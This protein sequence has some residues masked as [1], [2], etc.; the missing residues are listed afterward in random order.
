M[1]K[2]SALFSPRRKATSGLVGV[3]MMSQVE[4]TSSKSP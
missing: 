4:K 1:L 2:G 3:A